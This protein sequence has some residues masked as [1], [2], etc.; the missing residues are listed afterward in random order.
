[1]AKFEA[2]CRCS[3][4]T[5]KETHHNL[6]ICFLG[7]PHGEPRSSSGFSRSRKSGWTGYGAVYSFEYQLTYF[8]FKT[9]AK[10]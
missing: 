7:L 9:V 6:E 4:Q 8:L 3:I 2:S 1:M 10:A 5:V